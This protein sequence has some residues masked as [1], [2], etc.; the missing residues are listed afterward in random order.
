[1]SPRLPPKIHGTLLSIFCKV[2]ARK[3]HACRQEMRRQ[4]EEVSLAPDLGA[5][6]VAGRAGRMQARG[7][8]KLTSGARACT[9]NH[10]S[11]HGF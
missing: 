3:W 10:S 9:W 1:M 11:R 6:T 5:A 2:E 7:P 4:A 8:G